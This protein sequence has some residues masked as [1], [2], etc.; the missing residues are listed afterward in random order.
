M[1]PSALVFSGVSNGL[2]VEFEGFGA[3][4]RGER[5]IDVSHSRK[6]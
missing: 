3:F 2:R 1:L 4:M 6:K 5:A